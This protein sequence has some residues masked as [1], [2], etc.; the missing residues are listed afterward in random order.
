MRAGGSRT[1]SQCL[2]SGIQGSCCCLLPTIACCLLPI[3]YELLPIAYCLL[4][5]SCC[6]LPVHYCPYILYLILPVDYCILHIPYCLFP[7]V[8]AVAYC[9]LPIPYC[10]NTQGPRAGGL[11]VMTPAAWGR[12]RHLLPWIAA[13]LSCQPQDVVLRFVCERM[14]EK[15]QF[16]NVYP[17]ATAGGWQAMVKIKGKLTYILGSVSP[18][19]DICVVQCIYI[20][21]MIY[22]V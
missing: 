14:S 22:N 17:V 19:Q 8:R 3:A 7:T 2:R 6:F 15:R 1:N 9:L 13:S 12:A 21:I 18:T 4:P 16:N 20:D 5:M 10:S 11:G